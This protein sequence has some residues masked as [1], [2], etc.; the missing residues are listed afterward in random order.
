MLGRS[1]NNIA[2]PFL[3]V[4]LRSLTD[5]G[6]PSKSG[7]PLSHCHYYRYHTL[8]DTPLKLDCA[9]CGSWCALIAPSLPSWRHQGLA[10]G[11][12]EAVDI[13]KKLLTKSCFWVWIGIKFIGL[14]KISFLSYLRILFLS[15]KKFLRNLA[16]IV[17]E[18]SE[19]F[20]LPPKIP[21]F[22][23]TFG[24][25]SFPRFTVETTGKVISILHL[26]LAI[27]S[28]QQISM[29]TVK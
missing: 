2:A 3:Q 10:V 22:R 15:K 29:L 1:S 8:S 23:C 28:T 9:A 17:E 4:H 24:G 11:G 25:E 26:L 21:C 6:Q 7:Q 20:P 5:N 13:E 19:S 12:G 14:L 16:K 18:I 27:T